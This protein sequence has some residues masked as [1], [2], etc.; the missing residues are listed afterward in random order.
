VFRHCRLGEPAAWSAA[1]GALRQALA[2]SVRASGWTGNEELGYT[3]SRLHLYDTVSD[4]ISPVAEH[5][6]RE[7]WQQ[8]VAAAAAPGANV[9]ATK[10]L[11]P[12][13][14]TMIDITGTRQNAFNMHP[15]AVVFLLLF[16]FSF[17]AAFLAGYSMHARAEAGSTCSL[18]PWQ[19][20]ERSMRRLRS[21]IPGRGLSGVLTPIER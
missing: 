7:I 16:A 6:Q 4:E 17:G 3:T 18:S 11:L 1:Q 9:D 5:L 14:N 20:R 12:A 10:L 8:S 19:L 13:L 15:P 2:Y 21:N